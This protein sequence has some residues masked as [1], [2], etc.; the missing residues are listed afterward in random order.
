MFLNVLI[1]N[2]PKLVAAK[3][4]SA[5]RFM[6]LI[7]ALYDHRVKL[8]ASS[9]MNPEQLYHGVLLS[10]IFERT[11]SRLIEMASHDY[12]AMPHRP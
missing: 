10:D 3:D 1:S 7:D 2:I 11:V 12:L 5:K 4:S 9:E 8:I 6:H